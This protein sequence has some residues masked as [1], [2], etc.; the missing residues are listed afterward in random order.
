MFSAD[1]RLQWV[2]LGTESSCAFEHQ[3]E[4]RFTMPAE[5]GTVYQ[6]KWQV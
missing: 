5:P 4:Q 1:I 6:E 3:I 2:S